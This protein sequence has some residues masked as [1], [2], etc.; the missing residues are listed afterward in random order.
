MFHATRAELLKAVNLHSPG[1]RELAKKLHRRPMT[2]IS[3]INEMEEEGLIEKKVEKRNTRGRPRYLIKPTILG[4]DYLA[5]YE[6]LELK[7]LRSRK[8]DL[9]RAAKD[10]EYVKRLVARG[11]SPFRLFLELNSIVTINNRD[12]T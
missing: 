7:P 3:L 11:L 1:I 5:T 12:T 10:A 2:I 8:T 9:I 4:E 6:E